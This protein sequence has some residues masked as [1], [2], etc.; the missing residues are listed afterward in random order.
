[1]CRGHTADFSVSPLLWSYDTG[2][3]KD[4]TVA[5]TVL[6]PLSF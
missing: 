6:V 1:M 3:Q 5:I 2:S 4:R